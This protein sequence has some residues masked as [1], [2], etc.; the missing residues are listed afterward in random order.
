MARRKEI[1]MKSKCMRQIGVPPKA[2]CSDRRERKNGAI[3]EARKAGSKQI[4]AF[5]IKKTSAF[6]AE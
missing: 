4:R 1:E 3:A 6:F 5:K 2:F